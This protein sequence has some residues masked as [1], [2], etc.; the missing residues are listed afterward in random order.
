M[1]FKV[2]YVEDNPLNMFLIREMLT[3]TEYE[4]VEAVNGKHWL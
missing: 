1:A 3:L 4:L 2:L